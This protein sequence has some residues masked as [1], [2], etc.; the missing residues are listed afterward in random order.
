M[1]KLILNLL[2]ILLITI[3]QISFLPF[4]NY[5]TYL[6]LVLCCIIFITLANY[7][8]GLWW[9]LG[10]GLILDLYSPLP[11]GSLTLIL[12]LTVILINFLFKKFFTHRTLPALLSLGL[13]AT[14]F[15]QVTSSF[16]FWFF[17]LI[18]STPFCSIYTQK[19]FSVTE[20]CG[21]FLPASLIKIYFTT[22]LCQIIFN[23]I[24]LLLLGL[25]NKFRL[26]KRI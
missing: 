8:Q 6:N 1:L 26:L 2:L 11:F 24:F 16:L 18:Y 17:Y 3:L 19:V 7:R 15:Y 12:L 14:L 21:T 5:L 20:K 13:I 22:F 25:I 10:A 23:L 4:L 9:T